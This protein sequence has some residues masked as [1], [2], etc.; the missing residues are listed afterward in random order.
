MTAIVLLRLALGLDSFRASL[1]LGASGLGG[2]RWWRVGLA[3][4]LCDGVGPLV[5]LALGRASS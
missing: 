3:F 5:G 2:A 1:A 4:G